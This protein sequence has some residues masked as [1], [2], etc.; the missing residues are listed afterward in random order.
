MTKKHETYNYPMLDEDVCKKYSDYF[1][2]FPEVSSHYGMLDAWSI[3]SQDIR[4]FKLMNLDKK[5]SPEYKELVK[6][7]CNPDIIEM[8]PIFSGTSGSSGTQGSTGS[9]GTDGRAGG[10]YSRSGIVEIKIQNTP[11]KLAPAPPTPVQEN[12]F[13]DLLTEILEMEKITE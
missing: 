9:S 10:D 4:K 6:T 1:K 11:V 12:P 2:A 7:I 3:D 13:F 8:N 5:L